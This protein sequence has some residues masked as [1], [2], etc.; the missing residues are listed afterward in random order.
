MHPEFNSQCRMPLDGKANSIEPHPGISLPKHDCSDEQQA[1]V[2]S[3]MIDRLIADR[4]LR[5]V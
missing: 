5:F 4:S 2:Q 3:T 1:P